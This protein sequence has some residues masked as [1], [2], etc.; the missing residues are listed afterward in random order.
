M[1]E[2]NYSLLDKL[3]HEI[4]Y[5]NS[6]YNLLLENAKVEIDNLTSEQK[7]LVFQINDMQKIIES[8]SEHT[9]VTH[10]IFSPIEMDNETNQMVELKTKELDLYISKYELTTQQLNSKMFEYNEMKRIKDNYEELLVKL[11]YIKENLREQISSVNNELYVK[12]LKD[13]QQKK[14]LLDKENEKIKTVLKVVDN[15]YM[16]PLK[17]ELEQMKLAMNFVQTEP[18]RA[19]RMLD[20]IYMKINSVAD[21]MDNYINSILTPSEI[22]SLYDEFMNHILETTTI[23]ASIK[24]DVQ[25]EDLK[26]IEGISNKLNSA[27]LSMYI[28]MVDACV[29]NMNPE[30][31]NINFEYKEGYIYMRALI[32]G[33]FYDF[34]KEMKNNKNSN[35]AVLYEQV[36]LLHG[37]M[38]YEQRETDKVSLVIIVPVK[39]YM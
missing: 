2:I 12:E 29:F 36:F 39:N 19:K 30:S 37:H 38:S 24:V 14:R 15:S 25:A 1:I 17:S 4:N 3:I 11:E 9:D 7:E 32:E 27:L 22:T 18:V 28:G 33:E 34:Y 5:G 23:Y 26:K 10:S 6:E 21:E 31:I 13:I 20:S 16:S 8:Y 35:S